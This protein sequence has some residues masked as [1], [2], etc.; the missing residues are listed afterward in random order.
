MAKQVKAS[1]AKN[2]QNLVTKQGNT[3]YVSI[4]PASVVKYVRAGN[5]L[6]IH[7]NNGKTIRISGFFTAD[8]AQKLELVFRHEAK[9]WPVKA[10]KATIPVDDAATGA[11][12]EFV[13]AAG[14]S[15]SLN[16]WLIAG[17]AAGGIGLAAAGGGGGGGGGGGKEAPPPAA[18]SLDTKSN[19][20][21]TVTAT[22]VAPAGTR[23]TVTFPDGTSKIVTAG[24]DGKYTATSETSQNSGQ[25]NAVVTDNNG[26]TSVPAV[27]DYVDDVAPKS[28][29]AI[30]VMD[31]VG[32]VTGKI[33]ANDLTDDARPTMSG[34]A[35]PGSTVTIY[36]GTTKLGTAVTDS[37]GNWTFRPATALAEGEH[38]ITFTATDKAGNTSP[39]TEALVFKVDT[40]A[41]P[42]PVLKEALDDTG[43]IK[44]A[45]A[46]SGVTDD[47][48]PEFKGENAEA[49][50]TIRFFDNGSEIGSTVVA[51]DGTWS[52]TPEIGLQQGVHRI[53]MQAQDTAGNKS[54]KSATFQ[55]EVDTTPP[56]AP[57]I[58][59][60]RDNTGQFTGNVTNGKTTDET[61]PVLSGSGAE[62]GSVVKIYDNGTFL[63]E[64]IAN[65]NGTWSFTPTTD[66]AE[67]EHIFTVT[68]TD[69]AGNEGISSPSWTINVDTTAP[70]VPTIAKVVNAAGDELALDVVTNE[71][72][73]TLSGE[74]EKGSTVTIYDNG[75][76]IGT[77]TAAADGTWS[78]ELSHNL[79]QGE[80][81]FTIKA[82]D[83]AGNETAG[84][85]PFTLTVD[86]I[87]PNRPE[88]SSIT[89]A[90]GDITGTLAPN[91]MTDD[92]RPTLS[93][94]AEAGS[95]VTIYDQGE[96]IG[97]VTADANGLWTYVPDNNLSEGTHSFTVTATDIAGNVSTTS[98]AFTIT[99]DTIAPEAPEFTIGYDAVG[100]V[101]GDFASGAIINDNR[102]K[103]SG[104]G[105]EANAQ[106]KIYQDGALVATVRADVTGQWSWKSATALNDG[107]YEFTATVTDTAGNVS[108]ASSAFSVTIDTVA[109]EKPVIDTITDDVAPVEGSVVNGGFTNDNTPTL[110]GSGAEANG[111]IRIYDGSNLLGEVT[112]DASGLWS[113]TPADALGN[114]QHSFT[115]VSVDKAGN[116]S[117]RSDAYNVTIDTIAPNA[118]S[119]TQVLDDVGSIQGNVAS[120]KAT[121]DVK[122]VIS[123]SGA[124]AGSVVKLYDKGVLIGETTA[125]ANGTWSFTPA[126][127]LAEGEHIF[128]VT[129]TDKAGNEGV[130]SASWTINV[131][132]TAP[133]VPTITQVADAAGNELTDN[134]ITSERRPTLSG[135]AEAGS[136]VT[137]YDGTRKI[138][139]VIAEEDGTWSFEL[140]SSLSQG[141]HKFTVTT[142]DAAG[143]ES[144]ASDP[145]GFTVDSIAPAIPAIS[146]ITD[147]EG[148]ITGIIKAN[149]ITDDARPVLSGRA[150]AGSTVTIYDLGEAIGTV[151]ADANGDWSF[152]PN[153][154][155]EDGNHSLSVTATDAAG[156]VSP[157]S[158]TYAIIVDTTAPDAPRFTSGYDAVGPIT[159]EFTDGA[160]INDNR[161]RLS[162][163][164][165]EANSKV[166][167]YQDG[168]LVTTI[169]ADAGGQWNWKSAT[170]LAD[171]NYKFTATVE[172]A[173]GNVSL[174]SEAFTI[175]V[176]TVAPNAPQI[177]SVSDDQEPITGEIAKNGFTNDT[178]PTLKGSGAEANGTVRIYDGATLLGEVTADA[179][180]NWEYTP[181]N[182]LGNGLHTFTV[183]AVDAAGNASAK[184]AE[185]KITVDTL[186]PNTPAITQVLDDVGTVQGAV[187]SG[188]TTDD[189]KPTLSGN[190]AEAGS[191]VKIYDNGTLIGQTNANANG[192]WSFT[193]DTELP[194]GSHSFTVT[195]TDAAGNESSASMP[196]VVVVDTT[197]PEAKF[198]PE[199]T[200]A[201]DDVLPDTGE[202][203]NNGF[204]NDTTPRLN[205][206]GAEPDGFIRIYSGGKLLGQV[207]ADANGNWSFDVPTRSEGTHVF[208][209]KT[210]DAAGNE[211]SS[212]EPFTLTVDTTAPKVTDAEITSV[213]DDVDAYTGEIANGGLTN[214]A[215]P[216]IS[217][218][219]KDDI[220]LVRIY[221]GT[222]LL[223]E[224]KVTGG[225]WS[226]TPD[227]DLA[228]GVHNFRI[229]AVDGA[230][231]EGPFT[232]AWRVTI[233]T[234]A[235]NAP[236]ITQVL[237]DVGSVQGAV[238]SGKTTDDTKP[239]IS[240]SGAEG[241]STVKIY[242]NGVLLGET[243]AAAN[244][245]WVFTPT[246]DLIEGVHVFTATSTD[247]AGNE[248]NASM[249]WT[250]EVDLTPP[251]A[252]YKPE[253]SSASDDVQP[254]TGEVIHGGFTND[255]TPRLNGKGAEPNGF[256]RIYSEG[257]LLGQ[258]QADKDGNWTFDVPTLSEGKHDFIATTVDAAGN[259]GSSSDAFT[260]NVDTTAPGSDDAAITS[261]VDAAEPIT[262]DITNGGITNDP[263]PVIS[264]TAADDITLVRIYDGTTLLGEVTVTDGKWSF[265]PDS[266]LANGSH[267]FRVKAVDAAG[268]EGAYS[269]TWRINV[270][271]LAPNA[272]S[273]TSVY[274]DVGSV[275]GNVADGKRTDDLRPTIS[276]GGAEAGSVVKIYDNGTLIGQTIAAAN[277]TWSFTPTEDLTE[278]AHSFTVT[279]TDTAGNESA[280]SGSWRITIDLSVPKTPTIDQIWDD[281]QPGIGAVPNGGTT[282]DTTPTLSGTGA[283]G[284]ILKIFVNGDYVGETTVQATGQWNYTGFVA[285]GTHT[286]TVQSVN[287]VGTSSVMSEPHTITVSTAVPGTPSITEVM[288][289]VGSITGLVGNGKPTDDT[290]PAI[291]GKADANAKVNIYDNGA[292]IGQ[293]TADADGKWTFTPATAL[294]EGNHSFTAKIVDGAGVEGQPSVPYTIVVD[295]TAPDAPR[296]TV[297][298]DGVGPVIG[299]FSDGAIINDNRPKLSGAGAEPNTK[300]GI[301]QDD[302]LVATVT[303]DAGGQWSWKAT[304]ALADGTYKF[305]AKTTDIAGNVSLASEAFTITV[306]TVAPNAPQIDSITDAQEP[307]TGNVTK[308]GFTN[309]TTPTLKGSGAEANGLVRIYDGATMIG[310]VTADASGNWSYVPVNPLSNGPH[311]FTVVSVDGAGNVSVKSEGYKITVDTL[312]P[313][314]PSITN[315]VDD[316]GAV[317]GTVANG[318]T[319]DDTKPR[320]SGSGAESGSIVKIYDNG[321]YIGETIANANG[322]WAFT[323]TT[324][325]VEGAHSFTVTATD[326]AG[327]E[328][329]ESIAWAITVDLT[330]PT[331]PE[332][333]AV[334]DD[335]APGIGNVP[336]GQP[337]N[338]P[339][340]TLNGK[341]EVGSTIRVYEGTV[342]LGETTVRA[343]GTWTFT[344][345]LQEDGLRVFTVTSVDEAG[346]VS[347]PSDSWSVVIS[348]IPP[349]TPRIENLF[350][351][352]GSE[353]VSVPNTSVTND[354]DPLLTGTSQPNLVIRIYDNG[355]LVGSTT[356][357]ADGKWSFNFNDANVKLSEGYH[358]LS[359]AA[360]NEL[361]F[362]G[363]QS[364]PRIV[365][366]DITPPPPPVIVSAAD[367][368]GSI[369]NPAMPSGS[370]TDDTLPSFRGTTDGYHVIKLYRDGG[371]LVGQAI[372]DSTGNWVIQLTEPLDSKTHNFYA[373]ATDPAG[374]VSTS[375]SSIFTL[376]VDAIAPEAP[377][378][379]RIVDNV[380][381]HTGNID[382]GGLTNDPAPRVEGTS[383]ANATIKIYAGNLLV[384]TVRANASGAWSLKLPEGLPDGS[385]VITATA[386]D[387]AGNTG[388]A[389]A[390][391]T[392]VV[393]TIAPNVPTITGVIDD[394]P[395]N[396]GEFGNRATINDNLPEIIGRG[397][398][399]TTIT[400]YNGGTYVGTTVVGD[401]GKWSFQVTRTLGDGTHKFTATATDPAGNTTVASSTFEITIDTVAP[402]A[403]TFD[404]ARDNVTSSDLASGGHTRDTRPTLRGKAEPNSTVE[405]VDAVFGV[406]GKV[407]VDTSGNWQF[408]VPELPNGVY[409][410]KATA[411]DPAGNTSVVSSGSGYR[412]TVDT[413]PPVKPTIDDVAD[414]VQGGIVGTIPSNG[415]TNDARPVLK[416]TA[417]AG[418]TLTFYGGSSGTTVLGTMVV[419]AGG[420]WTW[421]VPNALSNG[422]NQLIVKS[423][424]LAGNA[425][426]STPWVILVDTVA[427]NAPSVTTV[428]DATEPA[429]G[430]ISNGG[431]TNETKPL[432]SGTAEANSTLTVMM[433][434]QEVTKLTVGADGKWT[435]KPDTALVDGKYDF[436]F[437]ATDAAGNTS[438][439][440]STFTV[441]VD[442]VAPTKP[443]IT[444]I[445]D[446]TYPV[447]GELTNG[448]Y[449]NDPKARL[450]ITGEPNATVIIY[451][452]NV[453][454]GTVTLN[455]SGT[456]TWTPS[457]NIPEGKHTYTVKQV[458]RAGL[459]SEISDPWTIN[460]ILN[461]PLAPVITQVIDNK[462]MFTGP[463][464]SGGLTNDTKPVVSGTGVPGTTVNLYTSSG[465]TFL[466]SAVVDA[467]G[468][469]TITPTKEIGGGAIQLTATAVD[470]AGNVSP[471]SNAWQLSVQ[472]AS[473]N[474]GTINYNLT[475][476]FDD[477][478]DSI[479]M[480]GN[481]PAGQLGVKL[482]VFRNGVQIS[483][484]VIGIDGK[485]KIVIPRDPA[486]GWA[487]YRVGFYNDAGN[488]QYVRN[489]YYYDSVSINGQ[490]K[491]HPVEMYTLFHFNSDKGL[492]APKFTYLIDGTGG[493]QGLNYNNAVTDA[494]DTTLR[495]IAK[496][497]PGGTNTITVYMD[498]VSVGTTTVGSDGRWSLNVT[499]IPEG[500]HVFTATLTAG[501]QTSAASE[502]FNVTIDTTPPEAPIIDEV[503]ADTG[504]YAGVIAKNGFTNDKTLELKGTTEPFAT[505]RIYNGS[506]QIAEVKADANGKWTYTTGDLPDG[507]HTFRTL[508]IDQAGNIGTLDLTTPGYVVTVDTKAPAAP[509]INTATDAVG[510]YKGDVPNSSIIDDKQPTLNG[511]AEPLSTVRIMAPDGKTILGTAVTDA[512]GNWSFKLPTALADGK[513]TFTAIAVDRA[514]NIGTASTGFAIEIDTTPPPAP[515]IS[516]VQ[517]TVPPKVGDLNSG[518]ATNDTRPSFSGTAEAN[519]KVKVYLNGVE[520]GSVDVSAS[521][522]WTFRPA[523]DKAFAEGTHNLTFKAMDKAGN[524]ST[525]ETTFK[526]VVDVTAPAKPELNQIIDAVGTETGPVPKDG[527]TDDAQPTFKGKGE[528]G[529]LVTILDNGKVL[530]TTTVGEDGTWTFKPTAAMTAEAHTITITV[531]D[532]AGNVSVPSDP[533][534]ITV[535]RP[536][537]GE[538]N[539]DGDG[540]NGF[541]ADTMS[542]GD[543]QSFSAR[544]AH[545]DQQDDL[546]SEPEVHAAPMSLDMS[547]LLDELDVQ[548]GQNY[549]EGN[550][551][552][553]GYDDQSVLAGLINLADASSDMS[554]QTEQS[555]DM[556]EELDGLD[557]TALANEVFEQPDQTE[558]EEIDLSALPEAPAEPVAPATD[559]A[560]TTE[561]PAAASDVYTPPSTADLELERLLQQSAAQ[562]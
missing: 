203:T 91:A 50:T 344:A 543:A 385:H 116:V 215:R 408:R 339:T 90:V 186:A 542:G 225:I 350:N 306:D 388:P 60:I 109:P 111:I 284:T 434:G 71:R 285:D 42:I 57:S 290:K 396:T 340:P 419:P 332:I 489:R 501:G 406:V 2:S 473:P 233:D 510:P 562:F 382:K 421:T 183:T 271:T 251:D 254:N 305:T 514:G 87:A 513:Y 260:L 18:P 475:P 23:V 235:P 24:A 465:N 437:K 496:F 459:E 45:I 224:V 228:N 330:P 281:A 368:V 213:Y 51:A 76:L 98:K 391:Y 104:S 532:A 466:G 193:P 481:I 398:K 511:K 308:D 491:D 427:P 88:I 180:G 114:G 17:L 217:G 457:A 484:E 208:I 471:S 456:A 548:D 455:S 520:I 509:I 120:G 558:A 119:I 100:P 270:D 430:N 218:T 341:G 26:K 316:I 336:N 268:N 269:A 67:G 179:S 56:T 171:G 367:D 21:G 36:D 392:I 155:F 137:I 92:A 384:G 22:G 373:T 286:F 219:A 444:S 257:K 362:E 101:V 97:F 310:E 244:G 199:I 313:S 545:D 488:I 85:D 359:A 277:G 204:T 342:L 453:Q 460:V 168:V 334:Y 505:I 150:E 337:T 6:V 438:S 107:S 54:E 74:A 546:T 483:T 49:G 79:T 407:T 380:P 322:T 196:W 96:E 124:E 207:Q 138:G 366:I 133:D 272:P 303:A 166:H 479:V 521:G 361:G 506:S 68:A 440:S 399:G 454:V 429:I 447:T 412:I 323:P 13:A 230:G 126:I 333:T 220:A 482:G 140:K 267:T 547:G 237:D 355:A 58:T 328:S 117:P 252:K 63:G 324:D 83:A 4:D 118:P 210:T 351:N 417:E 130:P 531:A 445:Y 265:A 81:K 540:M 416:G 12:V 486:G 320:L 249:P 39:A 296:F 205:G 462:D 127:D 469:W 275:Q 211:G 5:D 326:K 123:G 38:K 404:T 134:M 47:T 40:V 62:A 293:A 468:K 315:V 289:A 503:I 149:G 163:A 212:S 253:I 27:K 216:A 449:T 538:V 423:T 89:D 387:A 464:N 72:R 463:V 195:A 28:P 154:D 261:V 302:V 86:T 383:E 131:D 258:V 10:V 386:T 73:P 298:Y 317:T 433:N 172:D 30:S 485:Y 173:A 561:I 560:P 525:V 65:A 206:N 446:N 165:A 159:G 425:T 327:N 238:A 539:P 247:A 160:F 356:A 146:A 185:F 309:D 278:A 523:A 536:A 227:S 148:S 431:Y 442:T 121:D 325:L 151:I 413:V 467:T 32:T 544:S 16:P 112:A 524:L 389:S 125:N 82:T 470:L 550:Y 209:A 494:K 508:G 512:N 541:S 395:G 499:N 517:D 70:D 435:W 426:S 35:E 374:N 43:S 201:S 200:S 276:G 248:G 372:A 405:I 428:Y 263:R 490:S 307:I 352:N 7:Q 559:T 113:F 245:T 410:F 255:T 175:T 44:G 164:G 555:D 8:N 478:S 157:A 492:T 236:T 349:E 448:G 169:T 301:Y 553:D 59:E 84:T 297:G 535:I 354:Q 194:E 266:D 415:L 11:E 94:K 174:E 108:Q 3:A 93:G 243:K 378:I 106:V 370:L 292:I 229:K 480:E 472:T 143:N 554:G 33:K 234:T 353:N 147:N 314:S 178:T 329:G 161:P 226:F 198:K 152:K 239:T 527:T 15:D 295:T 46:A 497:V 319:T 474:T 345:P 300:V 158:K 34:K 516:R 78:L 528:A 409:N 357:D 144:G 262:G 411:T 401:D 369:I 274:D 311:T 331:K 420:N 400:I 41:P 364:F 476:Y 153:A 451:D 214:D 495:G 55:F 37:A 529:S 402:N 551:D 436:T 132:T 103:L 184:S 498:G 246:T 556:T 365:T 403:P 232:T 347:V 20:D 343:N 110:S 52:F 191:I 105:A 299:E 69:K 414:A 312:A 452:N 181:V 80:H 377:V 231:N 279:A 75:R 450:T 439:N 376:T 221:D 432:F 515:V 223:G 379:T 182:A 240:G 241:G 53:T 99:V 363:S 115:V 192:T 518:D 256:I 189:T 321:T 61:K 418:T 502:T 259:E 393:D 264:G 176:D 136:T 335:V 135:E 394:V 202:V 371:I 190:G 9:E 318:K 167:I 122:P 552:A 338:D 381:D 458:D 397:E 129:A 358:S 14:A 280:Q 48:R 504:I 77:V 66:L 443:L 141:E 294:A 95:R 522:T 128:T 500:A 273:I 346:N 493:V 102:P 530:G 422:T 177:D 507:T 156:N 375:N 282:N 390:G 304:D 31:E 142:T 424:D 549:G 222:T 487:D 187:A 188:K 139:T 288:D 145:F 441:N 537:G 461:P 64:T 29:E 283:P 533:W 477:A 287:E 526:V 291:S 348:T 19:P 360:V 534:K 557:M 25:V 197:P 242:D 250:I 162:G 170:A 519:G 1:S